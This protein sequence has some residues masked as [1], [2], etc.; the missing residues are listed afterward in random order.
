LRP[1]ARTAVLRF[2]PSTRLKYATLGV[3]LSTSRLAGR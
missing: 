3:C 2:Q 1:A